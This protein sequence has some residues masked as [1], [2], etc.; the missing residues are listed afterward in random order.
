LKSLDL[1]EDTWNI[2]I[3]TEQFVKTMN[4]IGREIGMKDTFYVNPHG[5][6]C[7]FRLEAYSNVEDQAILVKNL[8]ENEECFKIIAK[9]MHTAELKTI[10]GK[11]VEIRKIVWQNTNL[12]LGEEG[13]IGGK[14]GQTQN[15]G[16]CLA[17]VYEARDKQKYIIVLL[18]CS[19]KELRFT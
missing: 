19:T 7:A 9:P 13:F 10:S 5:L 18:G 1:T 6:D 8:I 16:N 12:L 15:A 3:Y 11:E 4:S 2:K 17:S 14:T